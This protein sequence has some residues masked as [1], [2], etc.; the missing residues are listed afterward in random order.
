MTAPIRVLFVCTANICRSPF[1]EAYARTVAERDGHD[2]EFTSAGTWGLPEHPMDPPMVQQLIGRGIE[3]DPGF[4]SHQVTRGDI[5]SADLVLTMEA[6]H[7]A[8][9][10]DDH[11]AA[12]DR[13]F[14]LGQFAGQ[15]SRR[16]DLTGL[17]LVAD[18]G[19]NRHA[20][21]EADDVPDPFRKG[22]AAASAAADRIAALV[23]VTL[24]ALCGPR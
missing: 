6:A 9:L 13:I 1:A 14:V 4:R 22:E 19:K 2:L 7:R 11:A 24:A 20:S 8:F 17:E 10:L 5:T 12:V 16:A 3:P 15:S 21:R 23:D 18:L